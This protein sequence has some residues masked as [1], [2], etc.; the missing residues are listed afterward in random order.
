MFKAVTEWQIISLVW[1][2]ALR[3]KLAFRFL[4][5]TYFDFS[6]TNQS[7]QVM[8]VFQIET[9]QCDGMLLHVRSYVLSRCHGHY[10]EPNFVNTRKHALPLKICHFV[11]RACR[12]ALIFPTNTEKFL[13]WY[14]YIIMH[15]ILSWKERTCT[16]CSI[17]RCFPSFSFTHHFHWRTN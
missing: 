15:Y 1:A 5:W 3:V 17:Y 4:Y 9:K 14:Q 6:E 7:T 8:P 16:V 2:H 12:K 11:L 10:Y 13:K